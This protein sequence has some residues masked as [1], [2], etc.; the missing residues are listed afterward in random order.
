MTTDRINRVENTAIVGV[1][2]TPPLGRYLFS[3]SASAC[4]TV[5]VKNMPT[6]SLAEGCIF[7]LFCAQVALVAEHE[8]VSIGVCEV[9]VVAFTRPV[10]S[11]FCSCGKR[12]RSLRKRPVTPAR[13]QPA[14]ICR[15]RT[16]PCLSHVYLFSAWSSP[17]P[18]PR[19]PLPTHV[20]QSGRLPT[21]HHCCGRQRCSVRTWNVPDGQSASDPRM[22]DRVR[23]RKCAVQTHRRR[24]CLEAASTSEP[25]PCGRCGSP[26]QALHRGQSTTISSIYF[27][28][29]VLLASSW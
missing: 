21:R 24:N 18:D 12:T 5:D 10:V 11:A 6:V 26:N 27:P 3:R 25:F 14:L 17:V 4:V 16:F 7:G 19:L 8:V 9:Q 22:Q 13:R 1:S 28:P 15:L 2:L 20:A 29:T 23:Q